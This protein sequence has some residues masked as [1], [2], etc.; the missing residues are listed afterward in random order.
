MLTTKDRI[1]VHSMEL[2]AKK[3]CKTITM[4]DIAASLGISKRTIYENFSDKNDLIQACLISFF[5]S[6]EENIKEALKSS[7]NI[8]DA[9]YTQLQANSKRMMKIKFDFFNEIQKYYPKVYNNVIKVHEKR[10]FQNMLE[11]L[12]KGQTDGVINKDIDVRVVTVLMHEIS[13][14]ILNSDKFD[15]YGIEKKDL[16]SVMHFLS[17]GIATEKGVKIIDDYIK[18]FKKIKYDDTI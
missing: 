14:L 10:Y 15:N 2:F 4:D 6:Q 16:M 12:Q 5:N 18:E 3:G 17:R 13:N 9:M 1:I 11:L 7:H 8:I